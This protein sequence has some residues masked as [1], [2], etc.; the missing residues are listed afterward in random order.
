LLSTLRGKTGSVPTLV[1]DLEGK[2]WLGSYE[3]RHFP[4]GERRLLLIGLNA[5]DD[6][7]RL[8]TFAMVNADRT[9]KIM[10]GK[11]AMAM[12]PMGTILYHQVM[13]QLGGRPLPPGFSLA[14]AKH[15][16]LDAV[17]TWETVLGCLGLL[18]SKVVK[19][20]PPS[21][22]ELEKRLSHP[23]PDRRQRPAIIVNLADGVRRGNQGGTH[24]S[25]VPHFRRGHVRRLQRE[26]EQ[27]LVVVSPTIVNA[28]DE[29]KPDLKPYIVK[30]QGQQ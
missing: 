30:R 5:L 28:R 16:D 3:D 12:V 27:K 26:D 11:L 18:T 13:E 14:N 23:K 15:A 7:Y 22:K 1:V 20:T 17:T 24:A 10:P 21:E 9:T 19:I 29:A 4:K 6:Q 2:D 25:P 8:D